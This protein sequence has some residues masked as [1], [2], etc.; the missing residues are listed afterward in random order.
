MD[1]SEESAVGGRGKNVCTAHAPAA[2]RAVE[3]GA[4]KG[5]A[6]GPKA[7]TKG[8]CQPWGEQ[9]RADARTS[10]RRQQ[11]CC[12]YLRLGRARRGKDRQRKRCAQAPD[13]HDAPGARGG[14]GEAREGGHRGAY[15][16][17]R[18][19]TDAISVPGRHRSEKK[20]SEVVSRL[21]LSSGDIHAQP[22]R[23]SVCAGAQQREKTQVPGNQP[24][25]TDAFGEHIW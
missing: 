4:R 6:C 22:A 8:A 5:F 20:L 10:A 18:A 1:V 2:A 7:C 14:D 12:N 11:A 16:R 24:H 23:P 17:K 21:V 9:A 25:P 3:V 19:L 13:R 15:L